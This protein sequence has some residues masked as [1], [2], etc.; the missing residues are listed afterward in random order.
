MFVHPNEFE[1]LQ[2]LEVPGR[3]RHDEA[4]DPGQDGWRAL[5]VTVRKLARRHGA[6]SVLNGLDL[7]IAAGEFVAVTGRGGTGKSTLL[8]I[9][10]GLERP[11]GEQGGPPARSP[12]LFDNFPQWASDDRVRLLFADARLL[13]W[14]RVWQ[15]VALG[16]PGDARARAGEALRQAGL[17]GRGG[18]W[19]AQL[20]EGQRQRVALARAL[21]RRPGLLLLDEPLGGLDALTRIEAQAAIE[22]AWRRDGFTAV[23]ATRDVYEAVALADRILVID[24]G[25]VVFDERVELA[26]PRARGS[27]AFAALAARV[28][29][30]VLK[31]PEPP[32]AD[33]PLAPVIQIRHLRLAV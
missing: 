30:A 19:P 8:R 9:L 2:H 17:A 10:A 21:V 11:T 32:D 24:E 18:D 26:R 5:R 1:L 7:D 31:E 20:T 28:L 23:L 16:L 3:T 15:N 6:R 4:P 25:A 13:P 29:R 22:Q 27:P 33:R 12:V 14:K